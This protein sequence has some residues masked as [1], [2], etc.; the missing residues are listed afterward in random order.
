MKYVFADNQT[1]KLV[2]NLPLTQGDGRST[3]QFKVKG[4]GQIPKIEN[5]RIQKINPN[6]GQS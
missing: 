5:L 6:P 3:I 2:E 1:G 4:E